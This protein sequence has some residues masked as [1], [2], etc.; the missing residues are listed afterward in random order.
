MSEIKVPVAIPIIGGARSHI[1]VHALPRTYPF[2]VHQFG[3]VVTLF[4]VS[5]ELKGVHISFLRQVSLEERIASEIRKSTYHLLTDGIPREF[6]LRRLDFILVVRPLQGGLSFYGGI[7]GKR[8][9]DGRK[10]YDNKILG[11][12]FHLNGDGTIYV[13]EPS[14]GLLPRVLVTN[15]EL[16]RPQQRTSQGYRMPTKVMEAF[17]DVKE[18]EGKIGHKKSLLNNLVFKMSKEQEDMADLEEQLF[19]T[20]TTQSEPTDSIQGNAMNPYDGVVTGED[21]IPQGTKPFPRK[22]GFE[23]NDEDLYRDLYID[24]DVEAE[25]NRIINDFNMPPTRDQRKPG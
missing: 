24:L 9:A 17:Q 5:L 20:K 19:T 14:H 15:P 21:R 13:P 4:Q 8:N 22:I 12:V 7:R 23:W 1:N 2:G 18:Y 6:V 25:S 16:N 3:D 10:I 11:R